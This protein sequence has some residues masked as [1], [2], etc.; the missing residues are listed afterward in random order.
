MFCIA[1]EIFLIFI[2]YIIDSSRQS[3]SEQTPTQEGKA[4]VKD[5]E[6]STKNREEESQP[7]FPHQNSKGKRTEHQE[8]SSHVDAHLDDLQ[9]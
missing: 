9:D 5:L 4:N 2:I 7:P 3:E 1:T 8:V 6:S